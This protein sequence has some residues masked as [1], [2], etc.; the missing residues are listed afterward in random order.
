MAAAASAVPLLA[1]VTGK[2]DTPYGEEEWRGAED[3]ASASGA[4][5][6]A[7]AGDLFP[8]P[9]V[10]RV[11]AVELFSYI[12]GACPDCALIW[13]AML[14]SYSGHKP[15]LE[16]ARAFGDIPIVSGETPLEGYPC[17]EF[18][19]YASTVR[20]IEHL[21]ITHGK[22]RIA[23]L[24][25]LPRHSGQALR[26]RAWRDTLERLGLDPDPRLVSTYAQ[27]DRH[28]LARSILHLLR[29]WPD[30]DAI[31]AS[32]GV[33]VGPALATLEKMGKKVPEDIAL[34]GFDD[35]PEFAGDRLDITTVGTPL[36]RIAREAGS[37]AL[38]LAAGGEAPNVPRQVGELVIRGSCGCSPRKG[39]R[40]PLS[41]AGA[42][43]ARASEDARTLKA[44][45][46]RLRGA[47]SFEEL[48][49]ILRAS[50]AELGLEAA[51]LVLKEGESSLDLA[52]AAGGAMESAA[53]GSFDSKGPWPRGLVGG[54]R[55]SALAISL[56]AD[57]RFIGFVLFE[58]CARSGTLYHGVADALAES[59]VA[60]MK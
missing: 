9:A 59:L 46:R 27:I 33:W 10:G 44:L 32:S 60:A 58:G 51:A 8:G 15:L 36:R 29:A 1:L 24:K 34:V 41:G 45:S 13:T 31:A 21:A 19:D 35:F 14:D 43:D 38:I 30:V 18:D 47:S 4:G 12:K 25:G 7:F 26:L 20:A 57:R 6:L 22:R 5:I 52:F 16:M 54:R 53:A 3:A 23:F 50:L 56:V 17:V 42:S 55:S 49:G 11:P 48:C 28:S 2:V 40:P 37:Q 39:P